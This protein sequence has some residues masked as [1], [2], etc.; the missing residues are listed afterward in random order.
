[1]SHAN[2]P[3]SALYHIDRPSGT[4]SYAFMWSIPNMIPLPP[5]E[6]SKMW[7]VLKQLDF[8]ST[9]GA[10]VGTEV[11]DPKVKGRVL[12]SMKIQGRGEGHTDHEIFEESWP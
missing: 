8:E 6:L 12:E 7:K 5:F 1:M 3:P 10:F 9:H 4:T 11:R 2:D